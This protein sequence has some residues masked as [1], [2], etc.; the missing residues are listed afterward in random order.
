MGQEYGNFLKAA[1][2]I[3][4]MGNANG[5][6]AQQFANEAA[7]RRTYANFASQWLAQHGSLTGMDEAFSKL[8]GAATAPTPSGGKVLAYDPATGLLK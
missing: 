4:N 2:N 6:I 7:T 3:K 5:G 8:K 1:P